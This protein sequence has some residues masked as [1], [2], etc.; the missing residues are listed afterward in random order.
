MDSG[1]LLLRTW[2]LRVFQ[3]FVDF[4]LWLFQGLDQDGF[5]WI[6]L[7]SIWFLLDIKKE[8]D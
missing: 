1:F 7:D 5:L 6:L 2:T 4:G 8:V 3:G